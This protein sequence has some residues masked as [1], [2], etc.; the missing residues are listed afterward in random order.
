[1]GNIEESFI[2]RRR[3]II[4]KTKYQLYPN[5]IIVGSFPYS[6]DIINDLSPT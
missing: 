6:R 3:Q 4:L 1:M 5:N 2:A